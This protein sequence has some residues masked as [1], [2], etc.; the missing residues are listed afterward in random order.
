MK[1]GRI[2]LLSF[3]R[4]PGVT[5]ALIIITF[6]PAISAGL[7]SIVSCSSD[8]SVSPDA[9]AA[10]VTIPQEGGRDVP[11]TDIPVTIHI[12]PPVSPGEPEPAATRAGDWHLIRRL[13]LF[14]FDDD[15]IGTLDAYTRSYAYTPEAVTVSSASGEKVL[16]A[17]ANHAFPDDFVTTIHN[18]EDLRRAV[19]CFTDDHPSWPVM[20]GETAFT[21]G[22]GQGCSIT[23]EPMMSTVEI[24][25]L[26]CRM[27]GQSLQNVKVYLT[28]VG[29]RAEVLRTEGF[30][31][32]ETLNN[33]GLS[34]T[35]LGRL[36]YSGMVYK[37]LGNGKTDGSGTS[38][39]SAVLYC[40][41]D[42]AEEE[43]FASPY[44]RLVVE[45]TLDGQP[46]YYPIPVNRGR[47]ESGG[48]EGIGR[49]RRYVFDL[50][51]TRPGTGSPDEDVLPGP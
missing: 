12:R 42:E 37:Y 43:S 30:L 8:R 36:A 33:G 50:T 4:S 10:A 21:A 40:Y 23:L 2:N 24:H 5:L 41:P 44:T 14:V 17:V 46:C 51:L 38:Y 49:N 9:P 29:N 13:D 16:V 28:G 11:L 47:Y 35:D 22:P 45:G 7:C 19:V 26:R 48:T 39:G 31:P 6:T 20:S 3:G 15:G 25:S 27:E 32:S 34:E 1:K 18:Y